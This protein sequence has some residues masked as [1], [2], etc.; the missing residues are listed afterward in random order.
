MVGFWL[1]CPG[2]CSWSRLMT[3]LLGRLLGVLL[4]IGAR[5]MRCAVQWSQMKPESELIR[6]VPTKVLADL[7]L[8]LVTL[9]LK[10][11]ASRTRELHYYKSKSYLVRV[12]FVTDWLTDPRRL[13]NCLEA[14]PS[15]NT[16]RNNSC[17]VVIVRHH[18]NPVYRAV[19]WIAINV[20][21]TCSPVIPT[22]GRF[23][24]EAPTLGLN[25]ST[26]SLSFL[27]VGNDL[28]KGRSPAQGIMWNVY[29]NPENEKPCTALV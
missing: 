25:P 15:V 3:L 6:L 17:I 20:S 23:P 16:A 18:G 24:W 21:V 7:L 8:S 13:V 19:A 28:V 2:D 1:R 4:F 11:R 29:W 12:I 26:V 9:R 5:L 14:D 10:E 22:C 27:R